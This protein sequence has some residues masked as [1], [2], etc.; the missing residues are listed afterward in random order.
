MLPESFLNP[1]GPNRVTGTKR[2]IVSSEISY[3]NKKLCTQPSDEWP[4][5]RTDTESSNGPN[6]CGGF[7]ISSTPNFG[8]PELWNSL[9]SETQWSNDIPAAVFGGA[10]SNANLPAAESGPFLFDCVPTQNHEIS[11]QCSPGA[12]SSYHQPRI[13]QGLNTFNPYF[14]FD[15]NRIINPCLEWS[16]DANFIYDS[17]ILESWANLGPCSEPQT[18]N[19]STWIDIT[20]DPEQGSGY[21]R[22][23]LTA[24]PQ[25]KATDI[26]PKCEEAPTSLKEAESSS[27]EDSSRLLRTV[28]C[29]NQD[30][31]G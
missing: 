4:S 13:Q 12:D 16:D 10:N 18:N 31:S 23:G 2:P 19:I 15:E 7:G 11:L 24:P 17:N 26:M 21:Q 6:S 14:T 1:P 28:M 29:D 30:Q 25:S 22:L 3:D 9:H 27:T 5:R 20:T 8:N